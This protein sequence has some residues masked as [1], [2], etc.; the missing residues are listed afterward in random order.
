MCSCSTIALQGG[1]LQAPSEVHSTPSFGK[2]T[3]S[4]VAPLYHRA[5]PSLEVQQLQDCGQEPHLTTLYSPSRLKKKS[6]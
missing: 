2:T 4:V 3:L 1:L 5:K 6:D